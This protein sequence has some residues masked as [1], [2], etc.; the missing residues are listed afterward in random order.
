MPDEDVVLDLLNENTNGS[1][2]KTPTLMA[3]IVNKENLVKKDDDKIMKELHLDCDISINNNN[4]VKKDN[5]PPPKDELQLLI[6]NKT[7]NKEEKITQKVSIPP[8]LIPIEDIE[9]AE[10]IFEVIEE[11]DVGLEVP[12]SLTNSIEIAKSKTPPV[13]LSSSLDSGMGGSGF[14]NVFLDSKISFP[15]RSIS[16]DSLNSE[17]SIDSN[18]SKSSLKIIESKFA[19]NGTLERHSSH[20]NHQITDENALSRTGLQVLVLWNN[21]IT[22]NSAQIISELI[23]ATSTLE[24]L[25][26]GRNLLCNE[27]LA[28]IKTSL[29]SNTSL[30]SIGFQGKFIEF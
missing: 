21:Q 26:V 17:A 3:S 9:P 13:M 5:S 23:E 4:S 7:K 27:F 20:N 15:E 16:S 28:N 14:D 30:T 22:R 2:D 12:D 18:D 25:N 19:R 8:S 29:K 24:I 11:T 1:L 10:E 6:D